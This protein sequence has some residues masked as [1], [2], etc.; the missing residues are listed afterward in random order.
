M[1]QRLSGDLTPSQ[2][3]VSTSLSVSCVDIMSRLKVNHGEIWE[4]HVDEGLEGSSQLCR[5]ILRDIRTVASV[6]RSAGSAPSDGRTGFH[7]AQSDGC[8]Q[9][10]P[11]LP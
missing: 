6:P 9:A 10:D 2:I 5:R 4:E 7:R 1:T 8:T 11:A 3:P